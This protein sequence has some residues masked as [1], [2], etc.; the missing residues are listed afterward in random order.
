MTEREAPD[1]THSD[2]INRLCDAVLARLSERLERHTTFNQGVRGSN[3]RRLTT[4]SGGHPDYHSL[5]PRLAP[6]TMLS[7]QC[8]EHAVPLLS[9]ALTAYR[10]CTTS[11]GRSAL[12]PSWVSDAAA[13]SCDTRE[14]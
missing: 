12:A 11:E 6:A 5:R 7:C 1:F 3:P 4:R 13:S 2:S 8:E 14:A 10:I 9:D